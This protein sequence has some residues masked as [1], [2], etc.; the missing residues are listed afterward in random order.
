LLAS[1]SSNWQAAGVWEQL[2]EVL[3]AR[4]RAADQID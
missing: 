2:H 3:L 1:R 4:L